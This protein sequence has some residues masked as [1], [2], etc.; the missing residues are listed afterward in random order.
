VALKILREQYAEDDLFIERFRQEADT[1]R[2]LPDNPHIVK[3]LDYGEMGKTYYL[4]MEFLEGQDLDQV[5]LQEGTLPI[6]QAVDIASQIADA[7]SVAHQREVVHRDVKPQNVKL[8]PDGIA[9]VLDFGIARATEGT[10]LTQT[11]AFIGTPQ[12]MAP[13]IWEGQP[14]DKRSDV[15]SLGVVL[16]EMIAGKPPFQADRPA[17]IMR[18]HLFEE[19]QPLNVVRVDTPS[20]IARIATRCLA[21][22]PGERYASAA[23]L[24]AALEGKVAVEAPEPAAVRPRPKPKRPKAPFSVLVRRRVPPA[25]RRAT[26]LLARIP[27]MVRGQPRAYL[28][29]RAGRMAGYRFRLSGQDTV[30]GLA[31]NCTIPLSDRYLSPHHARIYFIRGQYYLY[32]LN[33]HNGTYLNGYRITQPYALQH[34]DQIQIGECIFTFST[35]AVQRA[36][37]VYRGARRDVANELL[38]AAAA[39]ASVIL[40]PLLVPALIWATYKDRSAYVSHQA[41]QALLYQGIYVALLLVRQISLFRFL[42]PAVLWLLAVAGGCYAAYRCYRGQPFTYPFLGELA[43]RF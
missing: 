8:M 12:Y 38:A 4:A 42:S 36:A 11:G 30:L 20:R 23:E 18:Q 14:A 2:S 29:G 41:K 34:G 10:R 26:S 9:K 32:D 43:T 40:V 22:T 5:L 31:A 24:L 15:Y 21:K 17:A 13:E 33:S 35:Q 16:Y 25:L 7:L 27:E 19:P 6:D 37:G 1:I 39:H 28:E 3:P